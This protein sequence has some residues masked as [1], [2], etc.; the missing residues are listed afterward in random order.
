MT[1][2]KKMRLR[3]VKDPEDAVE[4]INRELMPF[5]RLLN[6]TAL[7]RFGEGTGAPPHPVD[8]GNAALFIQHDPPNAAGGNINVWVSMKG[9]WRLVASVAV[10]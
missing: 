8:N 6:D 3:P 4:F 2:P 10:V 1:T 9:V 5:L 7:V